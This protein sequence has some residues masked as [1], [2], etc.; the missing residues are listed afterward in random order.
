MNTQHRE[1]PP[2]VQLVGSRTSLSSKIM[3]SWSAHFG[4]VCIVRDIYRRGRA[5]ELS[6]IWFNDTTQQQ[7][8]DI[9]TATKESEGMSAEEWR[10]V[11]RTILI[12]RSRNAK[13]LC[14]RLAAM[15]DSE[16]SEVLT[17]LVERGGTDLGIIRGDTEISFFSR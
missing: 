15:P 3:N 11:V 2:G 17:V 7:R 16:M 13:H 12:G 4:N 6:W 14:E 1:V 10:S 9:M 8:D 5:V